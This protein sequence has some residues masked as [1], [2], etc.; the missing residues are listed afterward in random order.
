VVE[1]ATCT[2]V[3]PASQR[4]PE[5][6]VPAVMQ[7]RGQIALLPTQDEIN[8]L[9][10]MAKTAEDSRHY[11]A[12]GGLPGI[13]AVMLYAKEIG[14]PPMTAISGGFNVIQG[15][16][17]MAPQLMLMKIRQ[18]GHSVDILE[19]TAE[20]CTLKG[21]RGDTGQ[22]YEITFTIEDARR[23]QLVKKDSNWEKWPDDMCFARATAKMGRRLFT[24]VIHNAYVTGEISETIE[25]Q[26]QHTRS[27]VAKKQTVLIPKATDEAS[28]VQE[29]SGEEP[30][31]AQQSVEPAETTEPAPQTAEPATVDPK[32]YDQAVEAY[33]DTMMDYLRDQYRVAPEGLE[34]AKK[35]IRDEFKVA[36]EKAVPGSLLEGLKRFCR[37]TMLKTLQEKGIVPAARRG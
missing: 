17:E 29:T 1:V 28:T 9:T 34:F 30:A 27:R 2:E 3:V 24:D 15:R 12:M 6:F 35:M 33:I 31:E 7:H 37:F 26:I 32:D 19:A 20:R 16:I 18:A 5:D 13:M 25:T 36:H 8:V 10:T 22:E 14:I 21:K 23:A 11:Q 4:R